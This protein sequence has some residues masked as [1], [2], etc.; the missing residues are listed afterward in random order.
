MP[1]T[2]LEIYDRHFLAQQGLNSFA[3]S[4][5]CVAMFNDL[6][7]AEKQKFE[8]AAKRDAERY[9]RQEAECTHARNWSN[10]KVTLAANE[11]KEGSH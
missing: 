10:L 11:V 5:P 4:T 9:V 6:S 8:A 7:E 3:H 2:A 1:S